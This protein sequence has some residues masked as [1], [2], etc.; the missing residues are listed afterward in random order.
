M[1]THVSEQLSSQLPISVGAASETGLREQNQ[2]CMTGIS[3]PFGAA[4]VIADGMGGH[5]GGAEA[6]RR[7][8]ESFGR[9]LLSI[10][11]S[12]PVQDALS[13][14]IRFANLDVLEV[15]K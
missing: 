2:D 3:S 14:T 7:V 13:L 6:S 15:S 11:G 5:R 12:S 1:S 10:P 9:H 4:Y 8:V